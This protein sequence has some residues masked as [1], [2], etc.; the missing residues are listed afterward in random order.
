MTYSPVSVI[1][2]SLYTGFVFDGFVIV[3]VPFVG[4]T[5]SKFSS[6]TVISASGSDFV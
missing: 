1:P 6:N 4:V 2:E 5:V 3:S